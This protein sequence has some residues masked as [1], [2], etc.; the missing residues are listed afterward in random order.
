MRPAASIPGGRTLRSARRSRKAE[1]LGRQ[2]AELAVAAPQVI[3][4][5]LARLALAGPA[6]SARDRVELFASCTVDGDVT[7]PQVTMETGCKFNGICTMV[8]PQL[9]AI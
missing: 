6:P 7:A 3:A 8:A 4:H 9:D 2:A 5:R 1:R